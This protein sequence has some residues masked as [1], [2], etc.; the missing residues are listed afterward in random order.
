MKNNFRNIVVSLLLVLA[1]FTARA[2]QNFPV[3]LET[4][5]KLAS[6]NNL[7]IQEYKLKEQQALAEQSKAKEW[8]LPD[9]YTGA[10]THF[11]NGNAMNTDGTIFTGVNRD[12]LWAGLGIFAEIDFKNGF[13]QT[14]AAKQKSQAANYFS[15]AEKN[16]VILNAVQ[17][18]FDLQAEQLKCLFLQGLVIQ[19][20]TLSQ[21]IKIKVD[22]GLLY[23][24]DYLMSQSNY[25]HLKISMLQA[26]MEWQKKSTELTNLLNLE[27]SISLVSADTTLIPVSFT[28]QQP[29]IN[30][31]EK[32]QEYLALNSELQS[33]QALRNS[34]NQGLLLPKLRLGFD[35]GVFGAYTNPVSNTYQINASLIWTLPLGRLFYKGDL[36]KYD[37]Q[38]FIQQNKIE[39]F[40]SQYQKEISIA[41]SK[42]HII[43]EQISF[44]KDALQ[45]SSEAL[46]QS[47]ERQILGTAKPYE[48]FQA[49]QFYIEAKIEY[50]KTISEYNK[51]QFEL[52]VAMG[53]EL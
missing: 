12:I 22:A 43:N 23:Q 50:I 29:D 37:A 10:S 25:N 6:A 38:I 30:G 36:K 20:D 41:V 44:A 18:Y 40:K 11:L 42:I 35:N 17:I 45:T 47:I 4:V 39:Q 53:N 5:L 33:F 24:S 32:R 2:Q 14:L 7:T 26:K 46:S 31:F 21:Q 13:Y 9:I 19:A 27:N 51:A 1:T 48:V 16:K 15:V 8:W 3:N 34:T 52:M 28:V 49:Q